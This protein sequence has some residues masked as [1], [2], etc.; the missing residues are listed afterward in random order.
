MTNDI[1]LLYIGII[2]FFLYGLLL[3]GTCHPVG[4]KMLSAL[5]GPLCTVLGYLSAY[6]F[7]C[8][9]GL[10]VSDIHLL[11]PFL[12]LSI[13]ADNMYVLSNISG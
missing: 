7:C 8:V 13:G 4:C 2:L 6:G 11:L 9:I 10:K 5:I 12:L 3:L 1:F